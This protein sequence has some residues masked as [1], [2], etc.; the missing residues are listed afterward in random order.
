MLLSKA[1][2]VVG[3]LYVMGWDAKDRLGRELDRLG[4]EGS[5]FHMLCFERGNRE[6][7]FIAVGGDEGEHFLMGLAV[8]SLSF[9]PEAGHEVEVIRIPQLCGA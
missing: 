6:P 1:F 5:S 8:R 9:S 2:D 3:R 4:R 7:V